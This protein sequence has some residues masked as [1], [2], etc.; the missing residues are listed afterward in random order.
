MKLCLISSMIIKEHFS[1]ID[2]IRK[3]LFLFASSLAASA[4]H[5]FT[6]VI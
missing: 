6:T 5:F 1:Q 4:S 3:E 2:L